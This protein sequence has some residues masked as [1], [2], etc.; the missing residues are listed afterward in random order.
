M[1]ITGRP[2]THPTAPSTDIATRV[3]GDYCPQVHRRCAGPLGDRDM[4]GPETLTAAEPVGPGLLTGTTRALGQMVRL[5]SGDRSAHQWIVVH[6]LFL[7]CRCPE[8]LLPG[9]SDGNQTW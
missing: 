9:S 3:R 1:T 4:F 7:A 8:L 5:T 2:C 6:M